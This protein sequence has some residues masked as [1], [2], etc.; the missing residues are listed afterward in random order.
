MQAVPEHPKKDFVFCLSNLMGDSYL[1]QVNML[2]LLER[3]DT[4]KRLNIII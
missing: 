2:L 1:F 3:V 4:I